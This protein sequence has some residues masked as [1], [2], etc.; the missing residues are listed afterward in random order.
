MLTIVCNLMICLCV[1]IICQCSEISRGERVIWRGCPLMLSEDI[2]FGSGFQQNYSYLSLS[3]NERRKKCLEEKKKFH[4]KH[5]FA[6]KY[7]LHFRPKLKTIFF[8]QT[9]SIFSVFEEKYYFI[10]NKIRIEWRR[11]T[12]LSLWETSRY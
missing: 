7:L 8:W 10:G 12:R 5:S 6:S 9:I 3:R 4:F 1:Y 11:K 2:L